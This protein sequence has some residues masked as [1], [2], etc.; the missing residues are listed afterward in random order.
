[1]RSSVKIGGQINNS[2]C[3]TSRTSLN[4]VVIHSCPPRRVLPQ[5]KLLMLLPAACR[6]PKLLLKR[7][8]LARLHCFSPSNP[9]AIPTEMRT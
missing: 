1:M 9:A 2:V 8:Q 5:T 7:Y 3:L 6:S 4:P